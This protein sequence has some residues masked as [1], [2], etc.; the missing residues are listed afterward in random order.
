MNTPTI[1][2]FSVFVLTCLFAFNSW[3]QGAAAANTT[4][5][6]LMW[7]VSGKD[8]AKPSYLYGTIH[9]ICPDD[10]V[11]TEQMKNNFSA[12]EQL[13]LE[14]DMDDLKL[15]FKLMSPE[16]MNMPKGQTLKKLL[17]SADYKYL[18]AYFRDSL[19]TSLKKYE[20]TKPFFTMSAFYKDMVA[21]EKPTAYE[22]EFLMMAKKEKKEILG[23]ETLEAQ[24]AA[25]DAMSLKEQAAGLVKFVKEYHQGKAE[26]GKMVEFYRK[27]DLSGFAE[28]MK[29]QDGEM[30]GFEENFL[31]KRNN[32]WIPVMEKAMREKSTFFA[33][34]AAHLISDNGIVAL[35]RKQGYTVEPMK[36]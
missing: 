4:E 20:K 1:S 30:A 3:A 28:L 18:E 6:A 9:I 31:V 15:I 10:F 27:E 33:F 21:C 32:S 12:T 34:G 8:L 26:F 13:Y 36:L 23:L 17:N 7:K 14:M 29:E 11:M 2:F 19:K 16:T 22:S 25:V 35:L 24:L 5:N